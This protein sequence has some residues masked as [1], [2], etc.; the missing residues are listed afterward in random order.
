LMGNHDYLSNG[1]LIYK[2]LFGDTNFTF[3][4]GGYKFVAFDDV[5]WENNNQTPD[6]DWLNSQLKGDEKKVFLAH[7]PIWSDQMEGAFE[8][9]MD[10]ILTGKNLLA[11][12]YGHNH[13]SEIVSR[14]NI[15]QYVVNDIDDRLFAIVTVCGSKLKLQL[16]KF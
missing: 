14:D 5:V 15:Q 11:A 13:D 16:I 10:T 3:Q 12:I 1:K 7:I 2:R 4:Y 8:Q 6:F 9:K